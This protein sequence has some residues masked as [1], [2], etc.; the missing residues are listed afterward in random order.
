MAKR[1]SVIK[2]AEVY[3]VELW[4]DGELKE[5]RYL[6]GKSKAD[7]ES[8]AENWTNGVIKEANEQH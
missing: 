6:E 5:E 3:V 2:K 4:E 1:E 7:A 8:C